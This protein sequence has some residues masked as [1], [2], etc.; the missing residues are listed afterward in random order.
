[1]TFSV[2][3][4]YEIGALFFGQ[5]VEL[6][7]NYCM[8]GIAGLNIEKDLG[9]SL[10]EFYETEFRQV[11]WSVHGSGLVSVQGVP[12]ETFFDMSGLGYKWCADLSMFCSELILKDFGFAA[13]MQELASEWENVKISR[14]IAFKN[15]VEGRADGEA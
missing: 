11:C 3:G 5:V 1:L 4:R 12:Q 10:E 7:G 9:M 2:A 8:S 14:G 15:Q 6:S 13:H